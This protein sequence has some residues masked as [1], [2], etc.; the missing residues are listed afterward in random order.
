MLTKNRPPPL[1]AVKRYLQ[2]FPVL[3]AAKKHLWKIFVP[4]TYDRAKGTTS[5]NVLQSFPLFAPF[6]DG[7]YEDKATLTIQTINQ[8]VPLL[9]SLATLVGKRK[10]EISPIQSFPTSDREHETV[11]ELKTY[12]D[13]HGSDKANHHDYHFLYGS[14]LKNPADVRAVLEIGLGTD[15]TDVVS[16]MGSRGKPGASL[17]AF[18]DFFP[19]AKIY[20]AD[21][22][23]RIL[24]KED[25]IET[26]FVDQTDSDTFGNLGNSI[27]GDLDLAIDDGLH[28]P[29]ANIA[30]LQ[31]ALGKVKPGGWVV[32]EDISADAIPLWEVVSALLPETYQ[33]HLFSAK[34]GL[35]FAVMRPN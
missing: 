2:Q 19:N 25:R 13:K 21:V 15:N 27:P 1:K 31:F 22:D 11:A 16:N 34:A 33:R 17:R 30:T 6:S 26:F 9:S 12:L 23:K 32:I 3:V 4:A 5:L 28:S 7:K 29:N 14:I 35:V 24:F 10:L 20:G 8:T 18:R